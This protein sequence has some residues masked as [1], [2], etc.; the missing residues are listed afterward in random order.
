MQYI[1][2]LTDSL[3][4]PMVKTKRKTGFLGFLVAI[5]SVGRLFN[6]LISN[7]NVPMNYLL[8]YKLSQDHL[9]LFF[10]S[11]RSSGGWN[12]N[13]TARQ[14]MAAYKRL[15]LRHEVSAT[16]NCTALDN[17]RIL[18]AVKDTTTINQVNNV[19]VADISIIRRYDLQA[20]LEPQQLDHDYDDAPNFNY[21][22][23][24]KEAAVGY[25]ASFVVRMVKRTV[26]CETC[27]DALTEKGSKEA[28]YNAL[29]RHKNHGGLIEALTSVYEICQS[30][31]Q[32]VV[33][34]LN[35]TGGNLPTST[36]I[37]PAILSVVLEEAVNKDVFSSINNHMFD[38]TPDNNH[39]FSLIK[40]IAKCFLKI[41]M[42][43]LAKEKTAEVRGENIR[44]TLTKTILFSG[45]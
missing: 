19:G 45:Q 27:I 33:R 13:P 44:R 6:E 35:S 11:I 40:C 37:T 43:H 18:H 31:E 32:C 16:G 42:H 24:Y 23:T 3:G 5:K 15:L 10:A 20:R 25:I 22:S 30:T 28:S 9:E 7:T 34:M 26:S 2:A 39:L 21:L 17:T 1:S 14:F 12:N 29:V 8:T 41:R 36:N 4:T 38:S